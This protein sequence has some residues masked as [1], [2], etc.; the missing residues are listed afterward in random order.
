MKLNKEFF[1]GLVIAAGLS[2]MIYSITARKY[3]AQITYVK[4]ASITKMEP[5]NENWKDAYPRQYSSYQEMLKGS[6]ADF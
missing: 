4:P 3:E 5:K 2:F 1:I 6:P